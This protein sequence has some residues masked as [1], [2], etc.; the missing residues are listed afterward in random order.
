[1]DINEDD[2]RDAFSSG[3]GRW[4]QAEHD[5]FVKGLQQFGKQWKL[6]ADL[7]QTRTVVQVRT[8][9]QVLTSTF[10]VYFMSPKFFNPF[11]PC[12]HLPTHS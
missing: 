9:A 4:S 7:L 5:V 6:I 2:L 12:F 10:H 11:F 8:H 3:S 1:M